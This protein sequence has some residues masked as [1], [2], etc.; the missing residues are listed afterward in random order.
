M[1]LADSHRPDQAALAARFAAFRR[2]ARPPLIPPPSAAETARR[3]R[4][5]QRQARLAA[6]PFVGALLGRLRRLGI[7]WRNHDMGWRQKILATPGIGRAARW[8]W[9]LIRLGEFRSQT[10]AELTVLSAE[11]AQLKGTLQKQEAVQRERLAGLAEQVALALAPRA[12]GQVLPP[13]VYLALEE[14]LRGPA[15]AIAERFAVYRPYVRAAAR[16]GLPAADLGCGRGEWLTLLTTEGLTAVGVE[17][18][19]AMV[20]ACRAQGLPVEEGDAH[21]W[22]IAQAPASLAL[23][24]LFHVAEHLPPATLYAWLKAAWR[25]LAPGGLLLVETPNPENLQVAAYSFWFDPTHL[26]PLPPPLLDTLVGA[27]GFR[28][29]DILRLAPWPEMAQENGD[30]PPYLRKL[31]FCGQDYAIV[32]E[33]PAGG[34]G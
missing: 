6:W 18:N 5:A 11:L 16:L 28:T 32:A 24:S 21:G 31:L 23:V 9:S 15:A 22:L 26:R 30:Y 20:A 8:L 25:A 13:E 27:A 10:R 3:V 7:V 17:G 12:Q 34:E 1:P 33:K 19:A 14:R 29:V 2:Q 4:A